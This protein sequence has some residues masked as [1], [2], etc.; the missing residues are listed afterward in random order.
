MKKRYFKTLSVKITYVMLC[1][2]LA[3]LVYSCK[4]TYT[5][6]EATTTVVT[7]A[8]AQAW[9][10]TAYPHSGDSNSVNGTDSRLTFRNLHRQTGNMQI[11]MIGLAAM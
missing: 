9:Y 10:Q 4:K 8:A 2:A 1:I 7:V 5:E 3:T 6:D 11:R